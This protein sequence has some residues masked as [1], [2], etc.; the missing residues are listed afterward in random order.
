[1]EACSLRVRCLS[2]YGG[3]SKGGSHPPPDLV[4]LVSSWSWFLLHEFNVAMWPPWFQV[5]PINSRTP[6]HPFRNITD[7]SAGWWCLTDGANS[8]ST[9]SCSHPLALSKESK[10]VWKMDSPRGFLSLEN[11]RFIKYGVIRNRH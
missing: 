7:Q 11:H 6:F 9:H 10:A 5:L 3:P 1:M 8:R 4:R 2:L